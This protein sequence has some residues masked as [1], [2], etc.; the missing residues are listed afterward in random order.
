M[1]YTNIN[2]LNDII[3]KKVLFVDTETTGLPSG[4]FKNIKRE[5]SYPDYKSNNYDKSRVIQIGYSLQNN[6]NYGNILKNTE[7][8]II[9]PNG[10]TIENSHFHGITTEHAILTGSEAEHAFN[11]FGKVVDNCDYLIGYNIYFDIYVLLHEF[12][13]LNMNKHIDLILKMKKDKKI[14]CVGELARQYKNYSIQMPKQIKIYEEVFNKALENAHNA[15][16]DINATIELMCYFH[17]NPNEKNKII[18]NNLP[19]NPNNLS[20]CGNKWTEEEEKQLLIYINENKSHAEIS[21]LLKRNVG[22]ITSRLKR[23]AINRY[24]SGK[25][26]EEIAIIMNL[27]IET[28]KLYVGTNDKIKLKPEITEDNEIYDLEPTTFLVSKD[29]VECI[30]ENDKYYKYINGKKGELYAFTNAK[31]KVELCNKNKGK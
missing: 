9:K 3:G 25:T 15:M 17:N 13:K 30:K 1:S 16:N 7:G 18:N 20:N 31:N 12:Y 5:N 28:I 23:I 14:L 4:T 27:D 8:I 19:N 2:Y 29:K 24:T 10:F 22:G 11:I 6:F 26:I 21:N